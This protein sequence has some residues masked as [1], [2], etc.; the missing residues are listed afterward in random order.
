M[1]LSHRVSQKDKYLFFSSFCITKDSIKQIEITNN[2]I[3]TSCSPIKCCKK[4]TKL[5]CIQKRCVLNIQHISTAFQ[6]CYVISRKAF[7]NKQDRY[8]SEYKIV[9]KK[10]RSN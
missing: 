1:I 5:K 7:Y 3:I 2:V 8:N 10:V 6:I 4:A 9:A